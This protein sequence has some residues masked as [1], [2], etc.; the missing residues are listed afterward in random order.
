[1]PRL[2]VVGGIAAGMSGASKLKRLAPDWSV[3]VLEAGP[4]LSYGA[5]GMPYWIG[6]VT[7]SD[8]LYSMTAEKI[9]ERGIEV[10]LRQ[11]VTGLAEGR[12]CVTVVDEAS[13][14][15][16]EEAYDAL[17]L[18]TGAHA[19]LPR[20]RGLEGENV[21]LFHDFTQARAMEEYLT[22][23]SPKSALVWGAG[24]I[25]LEMAENLAA[26]G[27]SVTLINRSAHLLRTLVDPLKEALLLELEAKGVKV[28]LETQVREVLGDGGRVTALNTDRGKLAAEIFLVALGVEPSTAFLRDSPVPL[29]DN[30]A[31]RVDE[32]CSTGVHG[33]WA[34]GDCCAVNHLVTGREVYLPMGTTANKMGRVA[35]S[36][37]AGERS[38]FPG[39]AGTAIVKVFDLEAGVT[40]LSTAQAK[41][42]GFDAVEA[43]IKAPSRAHYYPGGGSV[44]VHL[45][46]ERNGRLLGGQ[47]VGP[48]GVKGRIDTLAAAVTAGMNVHELAML[49]LCYAPS[50]APVWDPLLVA[51]G[52]LEKKVT[53]V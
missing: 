44:H 17:L 41:E 40:G 36:N 51:A 53:G 27:I 11:R 29:A 26:R 7:G 32:F 22:K 21:F 35:G 49:D 52:V 46:A 18:A 24:Y 9:A 37:I 4:D 16:R 2:I 48:E 1:M 45:T 14:E 30:G 25:G 5:C 43:Y 39:V 10:R 15:N 33:I 23:N 38:R 34:A 8:S 47:V 28:L 12:K 31:I 19:R 3:T 6:G 50:F 20:I 13:G 42:A